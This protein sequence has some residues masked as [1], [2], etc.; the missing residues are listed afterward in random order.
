MIVTYLLIPKRP[1]FQAIARTSTKRNARQW[2]NYLPKISGGLPPQ[3]AGDTYLLDAT[4]FSLCSAAA[5]TASNLATPPSKA[6][7]RPPRAPVAAELLADAA[8][9][10]SR[11]KPSPSC[12]LSIPSPKRRRRRLLDCSPLLRPVCSSCGVNISR[13]GLGRTVLHPG[14]S[15]LGLAW[16]SIRPDRATALFANKSGG[17]RF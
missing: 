14:S 11:G 8:A 5:T 12:R 10:R 17:S 3:T 9:P 13:G 2:S 4:A 15:L 6:A 16:Q 1:R 7:R